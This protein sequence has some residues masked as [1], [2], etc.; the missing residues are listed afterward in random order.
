MCICFVDVLY[1]IVAKSAST[2]NAA[3]VQLTICQPCL[4]HIAATTEFETHDRTLS[5]TFHRLQQ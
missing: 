1:G 4:H 5:A 3:A 2:E